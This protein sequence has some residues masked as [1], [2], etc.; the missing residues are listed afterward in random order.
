MEWPD[1]AAMAGLDE[2]ALLRGVALEI[3]RPVEPALAQE[4]RAMVASALAVPAVAGA[5]GRQACAA[6]G[7]PTLEVRREMPFVAELD[8]GMVRGRMDR[9]VL[10]LREGRVV[11]AQVLDWK[12]GAVGLAGEALAERIAPYR[13][14]LQAY[15][16]ALRAIFTLPAEAVGATI[17]LVDRGEVVEVG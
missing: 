15:R 17:V 11:R 2:P 9:V 3:H 12:T 7:V 5:I 14:Q 6:W 10:G 4:V 8:G 1:A 16:A 13:E